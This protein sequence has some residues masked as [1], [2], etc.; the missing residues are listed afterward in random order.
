MSNTV[1]NEHNEQESFT[2]YEDLPPF[3][4]FLFSVW[5][6]K[7]RDTYVTNQSR[8]D[9]PRFLYA[10][11]RTTSGKGRVFTKDGTYDLPTNTLA[12]FDV[13]RIIKYQ[14]LGEE[15]SYNWYNFS[16]KQTIPFFKFNFPYD[17]AP[18]STE[19]R[20]TDE[21]FELMRSYTEINIKL[22]TVLF[23]E[24]VYRWINAIIN[25]ENKNMP[26]FQT[27][28]EVVSYINLHI[29]NDFKIQEL[30]QRCFLSERHFR[31]VFKKIVGVSPK[32]Y[33][34]NQ[35]L[36]KSAILLKTTSMSVSDV[37]YALNYCSPYQ[38]SK[39]FKDYFGVSPKQYRNNQSPAPRAQKARTEQ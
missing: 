7:R 18:F 27:I 16:P 35:K 2:I 6:V 32:S 10:F 21:M 23:C 30:A 19:D 31:L 9:E 37:A 34:C 25:K 17:V 38:F 4:T 12:L 1:P 22:S 39:E 11:I 36:K 28:S 8:P 26:H 13:N 20:L 3:N 29:E 15:W 24:L 5:K 14:P 33:I